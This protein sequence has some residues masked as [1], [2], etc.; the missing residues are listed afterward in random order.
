MTHAQLYGYSRIY[1][2]YL[3][4]YQKERHNFQ[5]HSYSL[6]DAEILK[7]WL[8]IMKGEK[9]TPLQSSRICCDHFL[10]SD[11]RILLSILVHQESQ[12]TAISLFNF[13]Y[14][15]QKPIHNSRKL[16]FLPEAKCKTWVRKKSTFSPGWIEVVIN[17]QKLKILKNSKLVVKK[18]KSIHYLRLLLI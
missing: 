14:Y 11:Y 2:R 17:K 13:P 15:Q 16:L 4:R 18:R 6:N 3:Q 12:K 1:A 10:V 9:F 7:R 5:F 8:L